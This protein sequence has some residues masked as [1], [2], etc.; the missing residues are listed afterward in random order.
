MGIIVIDNFS[1][2]SLNTN[3]QNTSTILKDAN[4]GNMWNW[5]GVSWD[6]YFSVVGGNNV[7]ITPLASNV[8]KG[9]IAAN[10][11]INSPYHV[12]V[13]DVISKVN[14]GQALPVANSTYGKV[15]VSEYTGTITQLQLYI[16][17]SVAGNIQVA[18]YDSGLN[19]LGKSTAQASGIGINKLNLTLNGANV[20][21]SGVQVNGGYVYYVG[22]SS[23]NVSR[24][25]W[26]FNGYSVVTTNLSPALQAYS[27]STIPNSLSSNSGNISFYPYVGMV[28]A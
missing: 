28:F 13:F 14:V 4:T 20:A 9:S 1:T 11:I 7:S 25:F 22:I 26:G 21:Q 2:Q 19:I 23:D 24:I 16:Q 10:Q 27:A 12:S 6:R 18:I 17:T 15:F 8:P 5:N 3:Y